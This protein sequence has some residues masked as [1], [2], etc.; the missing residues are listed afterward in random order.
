MYNVFNTNNWSVTE[1]INKIYFK[2]VYNRKKV[3]RKLGKTILCSFVQF[4]A[5]IIQANA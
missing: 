4:S 3:H 2:K 1:N 5:V